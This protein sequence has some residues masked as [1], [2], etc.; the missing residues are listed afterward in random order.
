M[1]IFQEY[2]DKESFFEDLEVVERLYAKGTYGMKHSKKEEKVVGPPE[3]KR[4]RRRVNTEAFSGDIS[5]NAEKQLR[6]LETIGGGSKMP[7]ATFFKPN[8]KSEVKSDV[9]SEVNSNVKS[10]ME[11]SDSDS[12]LEVKMD[13]EEINSSNT[14]S[15]KTH[16]NTPPENTTDKIQDGFAKMS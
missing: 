9:K 4:R 5:K 16:Q 7:K 6:K 14:N 1:S 8:N 11:G 2:I 15:D 12:N 13:V 3:S 10:E